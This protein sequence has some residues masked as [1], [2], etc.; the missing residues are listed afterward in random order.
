MTLIIIFSLLLPIFLTLV[1]DFRMSPETIYFFVAESRITNQ[2]A[3]LSFFSNNDTSVPSISSPLS[4]LNLDSFSWNRI[5][6]SKLYW[7][8]PVLLDGSKASFCSASNWALSSSSPD[9]PPSSLLLLKRLWEVPKILPTV[10][11][12]LDGFAALLKKMLSL[13]NKFLLLISNKFME[14]LLVKSPTPLLKG[15]STSS[16]FAGSDSGCFLN[17][18]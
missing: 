5:S 1:L 7:K 14:F 17:H 9:S 11:L 16:S 18:F 12:S 13:E 6:E 15:F 3:L 2:R 10:E 4:F 8:L